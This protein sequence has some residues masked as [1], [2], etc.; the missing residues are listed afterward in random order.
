VEIGLI[1]QKGNY[2]SKNLKKDVI[3]IEFTNTF[4]NSLH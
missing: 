3:F 1:V 2:L 4:K